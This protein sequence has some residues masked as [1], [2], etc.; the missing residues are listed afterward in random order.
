MGRQQAQSPVQYT[1]KAH[2][3]APTKRT[4]GGEVRVI[5]SRNFSAARNI[6]ASIHTVKPGGL[7]EMHWHP[8]ASE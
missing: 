6:A 7:R 3:M 5:D 1:F 8:N 4:A 2:S